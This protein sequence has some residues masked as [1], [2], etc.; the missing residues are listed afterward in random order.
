MD[1]P[2]P[3]SPAW[4]CELHGVYVI[5]KKDAMLYY[6]RPP[7]L[8]HGILLPGFF[9]LVFVVARKAP[10]IT[11]V[12]GMIAMTL[13]FI[14]S[15]VGP[16]VTPWER[17]A[18]TYERLISSPISQM[19]IMLGDALAGACFGLFLF[20]VALALGLCLT[21]AVV[22][23]P[24]MIVVA[25]LLS[26]P[27]FGC[28]GVLLGAPPVRNP[29][30]IMMLSNVVRMPLI[31]ISGVLFPLAEMPSWSR[32]LAPLSPLSYCADLVRASFGADLYF[33][34]WLD[35]MMLV[36]FSF[37]FLLAA[38]FIHRRGRARGL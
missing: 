38:R 9:F 31:F 1:E 13:F 30:Q 5:A 17:R 28:L 20:V 2:R 19:S 4:L 11:A 18:K 22:L 27:C 24:G 26:A 7:V 29:S 8:I 33:P 25:G 36:L 35:I 16:M 14:A 6:F 23:R 12:P 3:A 32:P 34:L 15:A 21:E 37:A 10:V